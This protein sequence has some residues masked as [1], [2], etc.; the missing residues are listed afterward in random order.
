[1]VC[2]VLKTTVFSLKNCLAQIQGEVG[3]S[4]HG[5]ENSLA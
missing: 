1:M 4:R 3:L 5:D 2:S